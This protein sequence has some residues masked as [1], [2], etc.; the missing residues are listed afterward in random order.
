MRFM[1]N[2]QCLQRFV[3]EGHLGHPICARA[4]TFA[5]DVPWWGEH[6]V[7]CI[8]GGGVLASTA[9][10]ILDLALWVA[11]QPRPV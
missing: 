2:A 10:H 7:K 4:W 9:V 6:Y 1:P 8:S 3:A 5:T 11:G